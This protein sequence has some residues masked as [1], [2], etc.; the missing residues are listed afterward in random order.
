MIGY[1]NIYEETALFMNATLAKCLIEQSL[2]LDNAEM[3]GFTLRQFVPKEAIQ[4][5]TIHQ[6]LRESAPLQQ[7]ICDATCTCEEMLLQV[8]IV[9]TQTVKL[10][11]P[12]V[13]IVPKQIQRDLVRC[14]RF[15]RVEFLAWICRENN[16]QWISDPTQWSGDGIVHF[17]E[18]ARLDMNLSICL[19]TGSPNQFVFERLYR[20]SDAKVNPVIV[21][22]AVHHQLTL[23]Q[24]K[25]LQDKKVFVRAF[26]EMVTEQFPIVS[27]DWVEA[28]LISRTI[29]LQPKLELRMIPGGKTARH[30]CELSGSLLKGG[31]KTV[32]INQI[33]FLYALFNGTE[34]M[35]N[36]TLVLTIEKSVLVNGLHQWI[37]SGYIRAN[38]GRTEKIEH[39]LSK[40]W[41]TF[42]TQMN[43]MGIGNLLDKFESKDNTFYLLKLTRSEISVGHFNLQQAIERTSKTG[44]RDESS[45]QKQHRNRKE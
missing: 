12:H 10:H 7:I 36:D 25:V 11:C 27:L 29:P 20:L 2:G 13:Q 17:A 16:F 42:Q 37:A 44:K 35:Q 19:L 24:L 40:L 30:V 4:W 18:T 32:G 1:W 15:S 6:L 45:Y 33:L 3:D 14:Y 31:R 21:F 43:E 39:R 22:T 28:I 38:L 23:E 26:G 8:E 34:I 41:L 5:A 9:D